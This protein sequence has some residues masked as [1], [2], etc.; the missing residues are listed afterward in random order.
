MGPFIG[1]PVYGR[2]K[3]EWTLYFFGG[4]NLIGFLMCICAIPSE[5]NETVSEEEELENDLKEDEKQ[6]TREV[7]RSMHKKKPIKKIGKITLWTVLSNKHA[8]FALL[9]CFVG[10]FDI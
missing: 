1:S 7:A 8:L 4:L 2:L 3:Y 9:T 5:L 6:T 10:T